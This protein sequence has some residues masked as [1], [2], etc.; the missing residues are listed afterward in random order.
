MYIRVVGKI[1]DQHFNIKLSSNPG[2][3]VLILVKSRGQICTIVLIFFGPCPL[4]WKITKQKILVQHCSNKPDIY[5]YVGKLPEQ[6]FNV[7]V[8]SNLGEKI[9]TLVEN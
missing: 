8:F 3:N 6:H 2:E 4:D 9:L 5:N 7:W 1:P